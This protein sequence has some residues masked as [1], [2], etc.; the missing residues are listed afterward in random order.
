MKESGVPA[1]RIV[2]ELN[3]LRPRD[4]TRPGDVVARGFFGEGQHLLVDVA[5]T[6]VWGNSDFSVNRSTP[7]NAAHERE[8]NKFTTD[9]KSSRPVSRFFRGDHVLIPFVMEDCGRLG[10]QG[11][12]IACFYWL[13]VLLLLITLNHRPRGILLV[14]VL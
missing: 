11:Q 2:T 8:K 13:S 7:G 14:L 1:S 10:D 9:E 4:Q 6:T 3:G 12:A 5:C